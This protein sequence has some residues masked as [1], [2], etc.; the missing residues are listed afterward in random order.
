MAGSFGGTVKLTGESEY[1][2]ALKTIT[3][4]LTVMTS[5][6]KLLSTQYDASDKSTEAIT[7]R[8]NILNKELAEGN[9]KVELYKKALSDFRNQQDTSAASMMQMIIQLE[10]EQKKLD[11]LKN[12][13][14]ST[15]KEI[16]EQEKVVA[17]LST[18][19]SKNE[20]QYEKNKLTLNKYEQQLN[21][22]QADVNNLT[23][24]VDKNEKTLKEASTS[25]N[26]NSDE[27]KNMADKSDQA[28]KKVNILGDIIKANL[29]SE[30][31]ISG[32]KKLGSAVAG[33]GKAFTSSIGDGIKY[34]S[35][36]EDYAMSFQTMTGSADKSKEM[37]N[38][39]KK[40]AKETPFEIDGM[41]DSVKQMMAYG[42][43]ADKSL[44]LTKLLGDVSQ[45]NMDKMNSMAYAMGQISSAGKLN[46]QDLR[47]LINAGFNPLEEMSRTTGESMESLKDK[48]SKGK[49]TYQMVED[50]LKSVTAAGGRF[51]NAMQNASKTFSGQMDMMKEGW[52]NFKGILSGGITTAISQ[53]ILPALNNILDSGTD[54]LSAVL[55]GDET[56]IEEA[57]EKLINEITTIA[58]SLVEV[59]PS[60]LSSFGAVLESLIIVIEESLPEIL[61][62]GVKILETLLKGIVSFIPKII[63]TVSS[64]F[65]TLVT[66]IVS[67]LPEILQAG[68]T[69]LIELITGINQTLPELIPT[70]INAVILMATTLLDNIDQIIDAGISIIFGLADGLMKALP[71]LIDKIPLIIDKLVNA[72]TNNL[73]KII[74]MGIVLTVKLAVGLIKA[75]PKLIAKIPQIITALVN[76][77]AEG[78]GKMA[79][80]GLNLIKGLWNGINNA[81]DWIIGKIKGFG[82]AILGGIKSFFGIKSP[83]TLFEDEVGTNLALGIGKGFSKEMNDVTKEMESSIPRDFDLGVTAN[84]KGNIEPSNY[85]K[86]MLIDA[87]KDALS[88]MTFQAFDKTFGELVISNVER[89][90]YL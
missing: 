9:K 21:L 31:I 24:E 34:N 82:K 41:A 56:K 19:L 1:V 85:S 26:K 3:S 83:S 29:I 68:I 63:P 8:N 46:G 65:M 59:I 57:K 66:T 87:F 40:T 90:V 12:S 75:I 44:E 39:I 79:G 78:V 38:E 49:I 71:D 7:S 48:M 5:E 33:L 14:S 25:V 77:L 35:M 60:L 16:K 45:G 15:S 86:E 84:Y 30:V 42:I 20:A 88:G 36:I 22:A 72:I 81:K 47:Q 17:D 62:A 69:V 50:S 80:V 74:E 58:Q 28:G 11:D 18:E 4:N 53:D 61:N 76:G 2:R 43:E 51:H 67:M 6:M 10:K 37:M 32:V 64:I 89:A 13:T 54:L 70:I 23:K 73:P 55:G 27:L 52:S